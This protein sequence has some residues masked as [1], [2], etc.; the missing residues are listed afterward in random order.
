M[1]TT[2]TESM[3]IFVKYCMF[4]SI[5]TPATITP[6]DT[7]IDGAGIA[8]TIVVDITDRAWGW[9]IQAL[10]ESKDISSYHR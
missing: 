8:Q 5:D 6:V 2:T 1:S 3:Q 9:D 4:T 10:I 7:F